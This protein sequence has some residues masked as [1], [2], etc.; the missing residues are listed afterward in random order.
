MMRLFK[1][2]LIFMMMLTATKALAS[3]WDNFQFVF[4]LGLVNGAYSN[5][6]DDSDA[7]TAAT[8]GNLIAENGFSV[9]PSFNFGVEYFSDLKT[10][11]F[12]RAIIAMDSTEGK[13]RYQ[14]LG[15]GGNK[16]ISSVGLMR[17][18]VNE[19][20]I[21]KSFPRWRHFYGWDLGLSRVIVVSFGPALN[22]VST[23]IDFG[24]HIGTNYHMGRNWALNAQLGMSY[25][26]GF[27]TVAVTG[28][29]FKIF[30]GSSFFF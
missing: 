1:L 13:M 17:S 8:G 28:T 4:N 30:F 25:A 12:T 10:S 26:F 3:K 24:G 16:Y 11:W 22:S 18:Y 15:L 21:L 2:S 7:A 27:S 6:I 14:Y 29:N 5:P 9:A 20:V 19:D 23:A